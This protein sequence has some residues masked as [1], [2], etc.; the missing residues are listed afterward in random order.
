MA[1]RSL[2]AIVNASPGRDVLVLCPKN[3][4]TRIQPAGLSAD[5]H[6]HFA[7]KSAPCLLERR[8]P[9]LNYNATDTRTFQTQELSNLSEASNQNYG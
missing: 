3:L 8:R 5:A 2:V 4:E 6:H 7:T 1:H 9:I